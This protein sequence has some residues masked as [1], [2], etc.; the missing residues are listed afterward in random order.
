M[1]ATHRRGLLREK[2]LTRG[3]NGRESEA[4]MLPPW[5]ALVVQFGCYTL[6]GGV[7]FL[8]DLAASLALIAAGLPVLAAFAV[9]YVVGFFSNYV[10]SA[11][12]AFRSGRYSRGSEITRL[13]FVNLSGLGLTLLL[14]QLFVVVLSI[15]P[16]VAKVIVTPMMLVW[17]FFGRRS[18]V[19]HR[20]MPVLGVAIANSVAASSRRITNPTVSGQA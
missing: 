9:G 4:P 6:V 17:N 3:G 16:L 12:V 14:I 20:E 1:P 10:L 2:L 18:F 5:A 7:A 11:L 15:S 8:A 13:V 19:F